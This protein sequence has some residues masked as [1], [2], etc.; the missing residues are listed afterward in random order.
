MLKTFHDALEAVIE[1]I[2]PTGHAF[3]KSP[4]AEIA[5]GPV[6]FQRFDQKITKAFF[7]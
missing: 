2:F 3:Q 1:K 7:Y 5:I 4:L 6:P